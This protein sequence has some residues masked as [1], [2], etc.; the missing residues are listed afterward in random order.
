MNINRFLAIPASK[1][2]VFIL[3][4]QTVMNCSE[5]TTYPPNR[6]IATC[7]KLGKRSENAL[8]GVWRKMELM[9]SRLFCKASAIQPIKMASPSDHEL[10]ALGKTRGPI[11]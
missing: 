1:N 11:S 3:P 2:G 9:W 7:P 4:N 10:N 6:E 5:T 8:Q